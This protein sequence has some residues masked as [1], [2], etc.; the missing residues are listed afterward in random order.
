MPIFVIYSNP[1]G[2]KD[3]R[4]YE[5]MDEETVKKLSA[6]YDMPFAIVDK[7][8]YDAEVLRQQEGLIS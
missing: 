1:N 6:E 7:A 3:L 4:S 2:N 8:T 5:G